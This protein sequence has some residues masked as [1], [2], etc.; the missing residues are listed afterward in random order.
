MFLYRFPPPILKAK[1]RSKKQR[2][3]SGVS[4]SSEHEPT[5][6]N[7]ES[8]S[9]NNKMYALKQ[10]SKQETKSE[11]IQRTKIESEADLLV[12]YS[13]I[14]GHY[15]YGSVAEGT[16]FMREARKSVCEQL[17][18]AYKNLPNNMSL[19][20]MIKNINE[21]IKGSEM[22]LAET[23]DRSSGT[24]YFKPKMVSFDFE[25]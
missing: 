23:L 17:N 8:T 2:P 19:D 6:H 21:S 7:G 4:T 1:K 20:V 13:T 14:P 16:F 11:T 12:Y 24:V 22:Q 9:K 15:S 5:D 25:S 10:N 3:D 18:E